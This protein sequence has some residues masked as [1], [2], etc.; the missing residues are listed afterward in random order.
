MKP[1]SL[2]PLGDT[3]R[4]LQN[5]YGPSGVSSTCGPRSRHSLG[6]RDDHTSGGIAWISRWSSA[7]IRTWSGGRGM[8]LVLFSVV[9]PSLR[10][11][12]LLA[13]Q[14]K[15]NRHAPPGRR[16]Q[17]R[18]PPEQRPPYPDRKSTRLNSSH[19]EIYTLSLHDALPILRLLLLLAR[20][21][22]SN[23]HAPPGRRAQTRSPPEQRP[24]Y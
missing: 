3:R 1:V 4:P 14:Y 8:S 11:L 6:R 22:K 20:Q 9:T 15:S 13:R 16:A 21:Y 7:E 5:Q 17:T 19:T 2:R 10:L 12:L 18:S 24:P 23:R